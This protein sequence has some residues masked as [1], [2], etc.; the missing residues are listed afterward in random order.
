MKIVI[1][2]HLP[3]ALLSIPGVVMYG[4]LPPINNEEPNR[5]SLGGDSVDDN[6]GDGSAE[7][8]KEGDSADDEQTPVSTSTLRLATWSIRILSDGSREVP[9]WHISPQSSETQIDKVFESM[10]RHLK[11]LYSSTK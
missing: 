6:S 7:D 4:L 9:N 10:A 3:F 2:T 11:D 5:D 1:L 8:D